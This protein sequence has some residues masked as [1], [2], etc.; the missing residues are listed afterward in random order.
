MIQ[1]NK[2]FFL[3]NLDIRNSKSYMKNSKKYITKYKISGGS[4]HMPHFPGTKLFGS[5]NKSEI[6]V[7]ERKND[8]EIYLNDL[9]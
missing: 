2:Q 3:L 8:I 6:A 4:A 7:T 5:T 1:Q 9:L